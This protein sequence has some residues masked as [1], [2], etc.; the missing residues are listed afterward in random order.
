MSPQKPSTVDEYIAN[1][2]AQVQSRLRELRSIIHSAVPNAEEVISYGLPTFK[3]EGRIVSIGAA[4]HH[5]A[6]YGTPM[7][8]FAEDLRGFRTLKGTVQFPLDQPV[9][10]ALVRKLVLAKFNSKI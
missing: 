9:P 7:D 3:L 1:Q 2:P 8:L 10:E 5:C 6:L 4:K